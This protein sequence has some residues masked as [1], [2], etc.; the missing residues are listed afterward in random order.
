MT[1]KEEDTLKIMAVSL[2]DDVILETIERNDVDTE[3]GWL[4]EVTFKKKERIDNSKL[5]GK[6]FGHNGST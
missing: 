4:L 2:P 5:K 3:Y 6:R 1:L